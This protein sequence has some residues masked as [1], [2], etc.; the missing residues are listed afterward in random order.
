MPS[1][2]TIIGAGPA[3][4]IAAEALARAG[5]R[6]RLHDA[7]PSAGRKLLMAGRGGLNLTHSEPL[8]AFLSRYGE[9]ADW[10]RPHLDAFTPA[11]LIAWAEGLGQPTFVGSSGRV[12]PKAMKASPL[13]RAW[14]G[15]LGELGVTLSL[16][17]RWT[18]WDAAGALTFDTPAGPV[19]ETAD[20]TVLALGGASW[21]RLGSDG[22]WTGLLAERGVEIAPFQPANV[23]FNVAWSAIF[24]ERFAGQPL[25]AIALTHAGQTVRG[26]SMIAGYGLEGGAI[27]ALSAGLRAAIARDGKAELSIDL[28]PD[29]SLGQLTAR[30]VTPQGRQSQS[31]H[32]RKAAHLSPA[33]IGLMREAT[34]G[35]I[36]ISP[37]SQA[38]LIKASRITVTGMQG[39]ER[40]ISSAGGLPLAELDA[41]LMLRRLPGVF[42]AGEMLD[43]EAPTGGYLLQASLATGLAAARGVAA[44]L[45]LP[46]IDALAQP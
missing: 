38:A 24:K 31:N 29:Q 15:R 19:T 1:D 21:P 35:P 44:R 16:R 23:G 2:V 22:G 43:W 25:K 5:A 26:E 9:A 4:L 30:L 46:A 14:L 34:G 13:L 28:H 11:D 33:A 6:V 32:L 3:G 10:A 8:E 39:L 37:R 36:P 7:M 18:G 12:F 42:A 20:A 45:N 40:A 41:S 27:Y 17:S